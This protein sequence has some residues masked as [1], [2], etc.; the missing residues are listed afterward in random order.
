MALEIGR[1]SSLSS[2][3]ILLLENLHRELNRTAAELHDVQVAVE[4]GKRELEALCEIERETSS[5]EQNIEDLRRQKESLEHAVSDHQNA[6]E[7]MKAARAREEREYRESL[8]TERQREEEEHRLVWEEAQAAAR[9]KLDEELR[10]IRQQSATNLASEEE[11]LR[12]REA[13]VDKKE[14]ELTLLMRELEKFLS[15]IAG[16]IGTAAHSGRSAAG[17]FDSGSGQEK[18]VFFASH[19]ETAGGFN[20][21]NA[22]M[23]EDAGE[24]KDSQA[25]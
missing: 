13:A 12:A 1:F 9:Q 23:W 19:D 11:A 7:E 8:E 3:M 5:L 10:A 21:A 2:E 22:L 6:W 18:P 24:E 14:Q 25:L 20:P 15:G 17:G 4:A 16:R